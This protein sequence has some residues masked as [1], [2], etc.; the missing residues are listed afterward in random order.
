MPAA[1]PPEPATVALPPVDGAVLASSGAL[2]PA[3]DAHPTEPLVPGEP[4]VLPVSAP[5]EP[6]AEAADP[7][8]R[9][10][11]AAFVR[12]HPRA[13]L[14]TALGVGFLLLATGSLFAGIAVGS[15]QGAPAPM[16]SET[17]TP[18]PDPRVLPAAI[19]D[20]SRLRTCSVASLTGD[21]RL[22]RLFAS[23][24][25][26]STGEVLLDRDGATP[27][28][29]ASAMKVLTAAAALAVLG[30][31]FRMSTRVVAGSSPG[32]VV[33]VGGGDATLSRL[34]AGQ[35]SVYRGAP[36]LDELAAQVVAAYAAANP[37]AP[38]ITTLVV[39]ASYWPAGDAWN[40]RWNRDRIAAGIQAPAT[41]LMV[42]GD[43]ADPRQQ[44]SPRSN[45]PVGRAGQA[46]AAAL[47][48]A[49]N[50]AGTPT[51]TS[52][53]AV[54][55]TV[56]GQV[57]SQPVGTLVTQMLT[58]TDFVLAEMLARV[59]SKQL[60]LA[61]T[62]ASLTGAI[63][64]ALNPYGVPTDGMVVTD[65]SG[66][67]TDNAVP[68]QYFAQLF[69]ILNDGSGDAGIIMDALPVAGVSGALAG[70]FSGPNA[71]ARGAVTAM[72]G[73]LTTARTLAGIV[74]A[75]DGTVLSI[76]FLAVRDGIGSAGRDALDSLA[77][78]VFTCG[79]NLSPN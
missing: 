13:V 35:E 64:G 73:E 7:D 25:N 68:A 16:V 61:G 27:V 51:I 14:A 9:R 57:Q 26:V 54:G 12:A 8:A 72:P 10:G 40:P 74:R 20:P 32:T 3:V 33:L 29:P 5:A 48:A 24:V 59:T 71:I 18:T 53:S 21:D 79:D 70:R 49:G 28:R 55:S 22:N 36:K 41:A 31:D 42:D 15:A 44:V 66:L 77:A 23:V 50:P 67:A 69:A 1:T 4:G 2:P 78:A 34:P 47:A 19:A 63:T 60:G 58:N 17:A 46:F 76:G 45:D 75:D 56:L 6:A 30:S 11:I 62:T 43:R 38:G 37:D 39:D 65:G 52:G